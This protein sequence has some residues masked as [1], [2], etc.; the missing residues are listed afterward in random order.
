[1]KFPALACF[2]V[3]GSIR[4]LAISLALVFGNAISLALALF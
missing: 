4:V 3:S 1:L 2:P